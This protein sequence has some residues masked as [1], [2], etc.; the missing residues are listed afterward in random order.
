MW[1]KNGVDPDQLALSEA[2]LSGFTPFSKDGMT[3]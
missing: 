2:N 3:F 1:M